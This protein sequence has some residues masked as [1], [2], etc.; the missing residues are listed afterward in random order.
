MNCKKKKYYIDKDTDFR[1]GESV[2]G[3]VIDFSFTERRNIRYVYVD[4]DDGRRTR[5]HLRSFLDCGLNPKNLDFG[6]E[7]R[8]KKKYYIFKHQVTKWKIVSVPIRAHSSEPLRMLPY[9]MSIDRGENDK[10]EYL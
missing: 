2:K 5:I 9:L 10:P 8:L 7:I 3:H 4:F 1:R 6:D